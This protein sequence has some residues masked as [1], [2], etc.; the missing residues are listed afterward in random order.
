VVPSS[1]RWRDDW[2]S[3]ADLPDRLA[4]MRGSHAEETSASR[5]HAESLLTTGKATEARSLLEGLY[6]RD[7][8]DLRT[9][10]AFARA[11]AASDDRTALREV[12]TLLTELLQDTGGDLGVFAGGDAAAGLRS[13]QTLSFLGTEQWQA[14]DY[15][16]ALQAYLLGEMLVPED[17]RF[18]YNQGLAWERIGDFRAALAAFDRTLA[19]EPGFPRAGE[20]RRAVAERLREHPAS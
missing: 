20:H 13:A 8:L 6:R 5:Q 2:Q 16:N 15:W 17:P 4:A 10:L 11:C 14:G 19:L 1:F 3:L 18:P 7:P 12:L 9:G